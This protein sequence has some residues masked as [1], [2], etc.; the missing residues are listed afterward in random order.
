MMEPDVLF[1]PANRFVLAGWAALVF[2]PG[3]RGARLVAEWAVPLS[4]GVAYGLLLFTARGKVEGDFGSL[5]GVS[6]LFAEREL[7]L[8]GWLH[9]LAF[10]LLIGS[11]MVRVSRNEGIPHMALLPVLAFTFLVGPLG[12][13]FWALL[14]GGWRRWGA[15]DVSGRSAG[16]E[17]GQDDRA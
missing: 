1:C 15:G 7:L 10:D 14:R 17:T 9:Y 13:V 11:Q 12:F 8:A 4:L 5:A 3:R 2:A 16:P 6:R